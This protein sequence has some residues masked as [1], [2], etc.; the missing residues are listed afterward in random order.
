MHHHQPTSILT[1]LTTM[2][3]PCLR[4]EHHRGINHFEIAGWRRGKKLGKHGRNLVSMGRRLLQQRTQKAKL[5]LDFEGVISFAICW[6]R[7]DLFYPNG[8]I[9]R[10]WLVFTRRYGT[11]IPANKWSALVQVKYL[12]A[13]KYLTVVCGSDVFQ[14]ESWSACDIYRVFLGRVEILLEN[15]SCHV[16]HNRPLVFVTKIQSCHAHHNQK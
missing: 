5:F 2:L 7:G 8:S 13:W 16:I 1:R 12:L 6:R 10:I 3:D 4:T 11:M 15:S 14:I 9:W